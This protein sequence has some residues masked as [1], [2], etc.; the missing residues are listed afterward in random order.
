M[1]WCDKTCKTVKIERVLASPLGLRITHKGNLD[2][3]GSI[4]GNGGDDVNLM[5]FGRFFTHTHAHEERT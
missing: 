1:K 3:I 5:N 4:C 2:K